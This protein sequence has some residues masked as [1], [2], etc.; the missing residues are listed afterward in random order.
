MRRGTWP[1]LSALLAVA[2]GLVLGATPAAAH[3]AG[4]GGGDGGIDLRAVAIGLAFVAAAALVAAIVGERS[5]TGPADLIAR[6]LAPGAAALAPGAGLGVAATAIAVGAGAVVV[7]APAR[8]AVR[9]A[10]STALLAAVAAGGSGG[11]PVV[12]RVVG[13][14]H[15]AAAAAW[16]GVVLAVALAWRGGP[17]AG[18]RL[19]QR[20]AVPAIGL[21]ALVAASGSLATA[22]HLGDAG[23]ALGS[24]W[25]RTLALKVA[26]VAAVAIAA[27]TLRTS[28]MPRLESAILGGAALTGLVLAAAGGPLSGP[29]PTGPLFLAVDSA[30]VLITPLAPGTNTV[31]VRGDD[32]D[33]SIDGRPITLERRADGLLAAT[34]DLPTGRHTVTSGEQR[35]ALT[36]RPDDE[37]DIVSA[38]LPTDVTDPDC[39]DRLAGAAAAVAARNAAGDPTRLAVVPGPTCAVAD[40]EPAG[41]DGAVTTALASLARRGSSLAPVVVVDDDPRAAAVAAEVRAAHGGAVLVAPD[42]LLT[43]LVP[44]TPIVVAM[45]VAAAGDAVARILEATGGVT[46]IVLAPW[47]LDASLLAD[48]A[49]EGAPVLVASHRDPTD[50]VAVDYRTATASLVGAPPATAAGLEGYLAAF[51]ALAGR[52]AVGATPGLYGF[53]SVAILPAELAHPSDAGWAPGVA[54]VR[55]A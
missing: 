38:T 50:R 47:L 52:P 21:V 6:V 45:S 9:V 8:S 46:P 30:I 39:L 55:V 10:S 32:P 43:G 36:V 22:E 53:S 19:T 4:T 34:V 20:V 49:S 7:L 37:A 14:G 54:L 48:L 44:G 13:G 29:A 27:A 24:W 5:T 2:I 40:L 35:T 18:R 16:S 51:A 3:G 12:D 26:L 15:V 28:W 41:W 17:A 25:G 23:L 42:E 11:Q 33:V 31:L 1:A